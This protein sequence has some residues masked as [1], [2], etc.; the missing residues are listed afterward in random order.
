[1]D[2][3]TT[4][5]GASELERSLLPPEE[6]VRWRRVQDLGRFEASRLLVS[7]VGMLAVGLVGGAAAMGWVRM[8]GPMMLQVVVGVVCGVAG[9]FAVTIAGLAWAR[10]LRARA[11]G[12]VRLF[13][14]TDRRLVISTGRVGRARTW[15]IPRSKIASVDRLYKEGYTAWVDGEWCDP[16]GNIGRASLPV[17][18]V[19]VDEFRTVLGSRS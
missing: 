11:R 2:L 7:G 19:S 12:D 4:Q 13:L 15:S 14:V 17:K 16:E 18:D 1:M 6:I 9:L 10:G 8:R 5:R 3:P